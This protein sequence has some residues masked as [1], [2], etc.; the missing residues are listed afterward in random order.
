MDDHRRHLQMCPSPITPASLTSSVE[1][2]CA[3]R[4]CRHGPPFLR[5]P[6]CTFIVG[7]IRTIASTEGEE[8]ERGPPVLSYHQVS[9]LI[10]VALQKKFSGSKNP[11]C[12]SRSR[13]NTS[14]VHMY[15]T[16]YKINPT[17]CLTLAPTQNTS[18]RKPKVSE[19]IA[20][21]KT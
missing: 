4:M 3:P 1:T 6:P 13:N 20:R 2:C 11:K 16:Q 7:E 8:R 10:F 5:H 12:P 21:P 9:T 14:A 15:R 18:T 17:T 19:D